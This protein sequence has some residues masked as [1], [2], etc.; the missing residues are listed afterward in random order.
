VSSIVNADSDVLVNAVETPAAAVL[1]FVVERDL[2]QPAMC[3]VSLRNPNHEYSSKY[4]LGASVEIRVGGLVPAS[5]PVSVKTTIFKGELVGVEPN[6]T[7]GDSTVTL[8]AFD[9]LHRLTRGRKS[10]TFQNQSDQDVVS[11]VARDHG[12]STEVTSTPTIRHAHIYQHNQTDLEFILERARAIGFQVWCEDTKLFFAAPKLDASSGIE[13]VLGAQSPSAALRLTS[14]SA[15][16]SNAQVVK[17]VIVRGRNP[18]TG[19]EI[20]GEA[21]AGAASPLGS[22]PAAA[23]LGSLNPI[24]TFTVDHPIFSVE[25]ANAIAKSKLGEMLMTYLTADAVGP[26]NV[27]L[28]PGIVI[29]IVVNA[30]DVYD[31]FSGKYLVRGCTHRIDN[32]ATSGFYTTIVRLA[33]DAEKG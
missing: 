31:R 6:H 10:R 28:E 22:V 5:T 26:G 14:F 19:Q 3:L 18:E 12:L 16:A 7:P 24:D 20:V 13:L 33:R 2:D 11:A 15:R 1:G 17:K 25:E 27:R 4:A 32:S 29:K 23:T 30:D 21:T 9:R 8:R